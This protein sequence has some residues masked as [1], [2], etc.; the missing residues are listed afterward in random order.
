VPF[1]EVAQRWLTDHVDLNLK[2]TSR[3]RSRTMVEKR[4]VPFFGDQA[5]GGITRE[6]VRRFATKL[7]KE[8]NLSAR[9]AKIHLVV[10]GGIFNFAIENGTV[11]S[12][13]VAKPGKIISVP[14]G[15]RPD[16]LNARET[17]VFLAAVKEHRPR[18]YA[19][20]MTAARAGLRLGELRAAQWGDVDWNRGTIT[21][22]RN[23]SEKEITTPKS[24]KSRVVD[25]TPQLADTLTA[26]RKAIAADALKAGRPMPEW[27]F[28]SKQ[29]KL[30]TVLSIILPFRAC[31]KTAKLRAVTPHSLRHSFA[32]AL[33]D[34]GASLAYV[35]DQLGH[36]DVKVTDIYV[37]AS[38]EDERK[39]LARLD[40]P[41]WNSP[42]SATP[43]QPAGSDPQGESRSE[44]L[45]Q[46]ISI[47]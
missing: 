36:S 46:V 21:V 22:Q 43:A 13:P 41:R 3:V 31:L 17:R 18:H 44:L 23:V 6:Q 29:G 16:F 5:I 24:G 47:H 38:P 8:D 1:K 7:R 25:M 37:H 11:A 4:F 28:P 26:H 19:M 15:D 34:A 10:L 35:R 20:F 32:S 42:K 40:D 45:S 27:I 9:T 33:L 2:P 14:K 12:N 39:A 30:I